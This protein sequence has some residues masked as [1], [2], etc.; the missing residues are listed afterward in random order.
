MDAHFKGLVPI[1]LEKADKNKPIILAGLAGI[2]VFVTAA[3][4]VSA[5]PKAIELVE[6]YKVENDIFDEDMTPLDYAKAAWKPYIPAAV[7]GIGTVAALSGSAYISN[8]RLA[9]S[10]VAT[11]LA[12]TTYENYR[13]VVI[14]K[15]GLKKEDEIKGEADARYMEKYAP[16]PPMQKGVQLP[17]TGELHSTLCYD[18]A[19]GRYFYSDIEFLRKCVNILNA[20]L[21]EEAWVSLNDWYELIGL[22]VIGVGEDIG[23]RYD[24]RSRNMVDMRDSSTPAPDGTPC[25]AVNFNV[26]PRWL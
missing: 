7:A 22:D 14:E 10:T 1:M 26:L 17:S 9:A 18:R 8:K 11:D 23:W 20:R 6:E 19:S 25:F 5:T 21:L 13:D 16:M 15:L 3:L 24:E 2:G 4:A 12:W